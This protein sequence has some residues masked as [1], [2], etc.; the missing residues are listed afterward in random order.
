MKLLIASDHAG[1]SLKADL[2][3]AKIPNLEFEDLGPASA[4]TSVD[5]PRYADKVC[6]LL[7]GK[8]SRELQKPAAILICGSGVG[9]S[10]RANRYPG[11]RAVLAF[12]AEIATLSRKHNASNVLC[13]AGRRLD[14]DSARRIVEAWIASDFEGDRHLRRVSQLDD[15]VGG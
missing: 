8:S 12:D 2:L 13:L 10:I 4:E 6:S 7:Q 5:Y 3:K 9:M 14:L 1:A 15:P 11:I